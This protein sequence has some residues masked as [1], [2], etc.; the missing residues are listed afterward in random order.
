VADVQEKYG[1]SARERL[2]SFFEHA[3]VAET[4]ARVAILVFK[5]E[6]RLELWAADADD[7]RHVKDYPVLAASGKA[8]PKLREGDR[9]VPEGL[10]RIEYLNPNSSYHLSMKLN[11]PNEFDLQ[12]AREE[13]RD[14]PGS[15]IFIHGKAVSIGCVAIGD[16]GTEEL[17]DLVGR[18][19]RDKVEVLIAPND[20]RKAQPVTDMK[21]APPWIREVYAGLKTE[22]AGFPV[23]RKTSR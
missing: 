2:R 16:A 22:L 23:E 18:T 20:L 19:G 3:D 21:A 1:L 12:K 5:A 11:Y 17:F 13:G 8:G 14:N 9:Q 6:K 10:Y 15:D 7:W 4:P